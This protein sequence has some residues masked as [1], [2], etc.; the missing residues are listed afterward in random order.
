[1]KKD[2]LDNLILNYVKD[3]FNLSIL[4]NI[5]EIGGYFFN[6][7]YGFIKDDIKVIIN[8]LPN[9]FYN[10]KNVVLK[11]FE[12]RKP[13]IEELKKD[14]EDLENKSLSLIAT[15]KFADLLS[16][17]LVSYYEIKVSNASLIF[18]LDVDD[19][20]EDVYENIEDYVKNN[21]LKRNGGTLLK[22]L[23]CNMTRDNYKSYINRSFNDLLKNTPEYI[24]DATI[25]T[26]KFKFAPFIYLEQS[27]EKDKLFEIFNKKYENMEEEELLEMLEIIENISKDY[28]NQIGDIRAIYSCFI[29]ILAIYT[30][31]INI[32]Y[33]FDNDFVVKDMYYYTCEMIENRDYSTYDNIKNNLENKCEKLIKSVEKN[34]KSLEKVLRQKPYNEDSETIKTF[35]ALETYSGL[36]FET[37]ILFKSDVSKSNIATKSYIDEKLDDFILFVNNLNINNY[38]LKILKQQFFSEIPCPLNESELKIHFK[39]ILTGLKKET[40]FLVC[41][42]FLDLF[43]DNKEQH[44][45]TNCSH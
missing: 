37:N 19:F 36:N 15:L 31:V 29:D 16:Y 11:N 4:N 20:L 41:Y 2:E 21:K 42:K 1:M 18:D 8:K 35:L 3:K 30:F 38:M 39:N 6:D 10:I 34:R 24:V 28:S 40:F 25:N 23:P 27:E 7:S 5:Y 12:D 14:I 44:F 45:C 33:I 9:Y 22:I 26:F 43:D 13:F 17:T 32:D